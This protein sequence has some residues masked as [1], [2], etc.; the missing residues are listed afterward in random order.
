M[1]RALRDTAGVLLAVA[2]VV[3]ARSASAKLPALQ[4]QNQQPPVRTILYKENTVLTEGHKRLEEMKVELALLSDIATFPYCLGVHAT[5]G[6][7]E[8]RGYVPN[9]MVRQRALELART[10]TFLMVNDGLRIQSNLSMRPALRPARVLQQEG[11]KLLQKN[12]GEPARLMALNVRAN[13]VIDV[14]GPIDSMESKLAVSRLFRQLPGCFGVINELTVQPVLRDGQRVVQVTRDGSIV[15]PP[16]ALGRG[17][18]RPAAFPPVP[19][20]PK[21]VAPAL[22]AAAPAPLPKASQP[23]RIPEKK[24]SPPAGQQPTILP[25]P[26]PLPTSSLEAQKD[27]LRLPSAVPPKPASTQ[28]KPKPETIGSVSDTSTELKLPVKWGRPTMSWESQVKQLEATNA[29]PASPTPSA[30]RASGEEAKM[31]T[32]VSAASRPA[33]TKWSRILPAESTSICVNKTPHLD[34]AETRAVPTAEWSAAGLPAATASSPVSASAG[35]PSAKVPAQRPKEPEPRAS[36]SPAQ[37]EKRPAVPVPFPTP[38]PA[39]TWRPPGNSEESEPRVQTATKPTDTLP[40][41][42]AK[43]R[44]ARMPAVRTL[45]SP[46]RWPPAYETRPPESKGRPGVIFFDDD[47]PPP[48]KPAPVAAGTSHPIVPVAAG[49]SHPIVPADLQRQVQSICGRQAREV[50]VEMQHD[51]FLLVR[52]K[53]PSL[54]VESQLTPKIL[55]IPAM[56]SPKVRL[57]MNVGP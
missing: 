31:P 55:A 46:R 38:M 20:M 5:G 28:P 26:T 36:A 11:V 19:A 51:G 53:V 4:P 25:S 17:P 23:T 41:A 24:P 27:E 16:S 35:T 32:P 33:E 52:V 44:P 18:E 39:M 13:G 43:P 14:T 57:L 54:S 2:A 47:P 49:T 30:P 48:S 12:F 34:F 15:V 10:N 50:T 22:S 37:A 7:L 21:P 40:S 6:T 3:A 42:P 8:L 1:R 56:T 45:S 9:D 29:S